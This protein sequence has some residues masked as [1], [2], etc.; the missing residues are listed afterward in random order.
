VLGHEGSES[1]LSPLTGG[2]HCHQARLR[3]SRGYAV[4]NETF[5]YRTWPSIT[6]EHI[7]EFIYSVDNIATKQIFERRE[8][9]LYVRPAEFP[10]TKLLSPFEH[11]YFL[12][13]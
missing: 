4:S 7:L 9:V 2:L 6:L 3:T 5:A 8:V 13:G 10:S 12:R 11:A 1:T